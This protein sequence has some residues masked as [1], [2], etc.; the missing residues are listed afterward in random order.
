MPTTL[1]F[2]EILEALKNGVTDLAKSTVKNYL[3]HAKE[4]G[5]KLIESMK[6]KLERWTRLL[7]DKKL[8][9]EDFEWLVN[10][11]KDVV[12]MDALKEAGLA[13]IRVDQFKS[14]VFNLIVDT[15]FHAVKP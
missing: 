3:Q 15:I 10:S 2:N 8:T 6:V 9:A 4:D 5:E 13:A 14:S 11:Q 12:Q 7:I 1:H